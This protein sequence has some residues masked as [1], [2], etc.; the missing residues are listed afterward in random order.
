[1]ACVSVRGTG[2]V[3]QADLNGAANLLKRY[4]LGECRGVAFPGK[5]ERAR[6]WRW[7]GRWN[8]FVEVSPRA[9]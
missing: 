2:W 5:L 7:D 4:M 1:M 6:V 9:A 3:V 8:R